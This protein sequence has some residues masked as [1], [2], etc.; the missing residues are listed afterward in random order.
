MRSL[1]ISIYFE[2]VSLV[3]LVSNNPSLSE[4]IFDYTSENSV[5]NSNSLKDIVVSPQLKSLD[6]TLNYW[7]V[8]FF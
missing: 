6:L 5:E 1:S 4:I 7:L 3:A 2:P 8:D